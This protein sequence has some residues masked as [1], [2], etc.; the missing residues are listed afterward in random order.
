MRAST[1]R[2]LAAQLLI[3]MRFAEYLEQLQTATQ[4]KVASKKKKH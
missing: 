3:D 2:K 1:I 4:A